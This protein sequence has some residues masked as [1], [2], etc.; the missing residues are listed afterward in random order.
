M[1][2][3]RAGA[4]SIPILNFCDRNAFDNYKDAR[5]ELS[6][7]ALELFERDTCLIKDTSECT[8]WKNLPVYRNDNDAASAVAEFSVGTPLR[9]FMEAEPF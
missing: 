8:D 9:F 4:R 2:F 5:L 1:C 6:R 3:D 7:L